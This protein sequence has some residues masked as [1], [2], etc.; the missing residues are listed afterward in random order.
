MFLILF[1]F[2]AWLAVTVPASLFLGFLIH[3]MG[4][5]K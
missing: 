5:G 2:I 4:R 1:V 3:E